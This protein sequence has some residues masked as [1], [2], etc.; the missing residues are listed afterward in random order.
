MWQGGMLFPKMV[1]ESPVDLFLAGFGITMQR[2]DDGLFVADSPYVASKLLANMFE[3]G[4]KMFNSVRVQDVIYRKDRITGV[5]INW[6]QVAHLTA[7]C[8]D[9]LAF[10]SKVVID[11]T[12]H[13]AEVAKV[14]AEKIGALQ[15]FV[16]REGSMWIDESEKAT[17]ANT[18]E[19]YPGLIMTGMAANSLAGNPRPGPVFGGMFLSGIKAA[20][21]AL[22]KINGGRFK[23]NSIAPEVIASI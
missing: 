3:F 14:V 8:V 18:R 10:E 17:V 21:L 13:S 6:D 2:K 16:G 7:N 19:V 5:V 15:P 23:K 9:P 12:G 20:K 22:Q 11:A 1:V 4:A